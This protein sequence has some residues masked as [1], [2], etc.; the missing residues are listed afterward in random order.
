MKSK[1]ELLFEAYL[2]QCKITYK[3]EPFR[4]SK[5][6]DYLFKHHGKTI[7]VEIKELEETPLDR[8]TNTSLAKGG[9]TFSLDPG[10]LYRILRRRIDA[11]CRQLKPHG[12]KVDYCRVILGNK[13]GSDLDLD[14]VFYAMYGDL[15]LSIPFDIQ[16]VGSM[17]KAESRMKATGSLRKHHP[18]N[19]QM[20]SP[21]TYLGG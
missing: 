20:Y 5:N 6:P 18:S 13:A 2:R 11:A 1:T 10:E 15:Y 21:H 9:G 16:G 12:A 8:A 19:K 17:A 4:G 14:S 7:L 3:N